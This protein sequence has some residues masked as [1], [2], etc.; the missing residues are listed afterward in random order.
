MPKSRHRKNHKTKVKSFK[1]KAVAAKN[2]EIKEYREK[3]EEVYKKA[4]GVLE[5]GKE[6]KEEKPMKIESGAISPDSKNNNNN[7]NKIKI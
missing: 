1:K 4:Q 7:L 6:K 2:A 3:M 5:E